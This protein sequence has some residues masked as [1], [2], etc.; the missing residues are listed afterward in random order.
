MAALD[1]AESVLSRDRWP[2]LAERGDAE[3]W[4]DVL[5]GGGKR[6]CDPR[7][8]L[9]MGLSRRP[10]ASGLWRRPLSTSMCFRTDLWFESG[11]AL[12]MG[13]MPREW[14]N[15]RAPKPGP[16]GLSGV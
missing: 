11:A 13:G 8:G 9:P 2:N 14:E 5:L 10:L 3:I 15:L 7:V 1:V 4:P 12:F 16:G 6:S